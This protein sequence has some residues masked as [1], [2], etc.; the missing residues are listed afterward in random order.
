MRA[1]HSRIA[2]IV[3]FALV[4]ICCNSN[5]SRAA[6]PTV[7]AFVPTSGTIGTKITV[8][9]AGFTGTTAVK[10]GGAAAT[11]MV[12]SDKALVV[13]VPVNAATGAIFVTTAGGTGRSAK[14][15]TMIP[16]VKL[17]PASRRP[18]SLLNISGAGFHHST[19]VDVFFDTAD[20]ALSV[21]NGLGLVSA[22]IQVPSWAQPGQHWVT[23]VE[24]GTSAA[25]QQSLVVNTDWTMAGFAP[26]GRGFNPF[27]NTINASNVVQLAPTWQVQVSQFSNAAPFVALNGNL[28]VGE[29]GGNIKAVSSA[30]AVLWTAATG[31]SISKAPAAA[32]NRVFFPAADGNVRAYSA[33]CR[34]DGGVCAPLWTTSVGTNVPGDLVVFDG[35]VYA[36][37]SDGSIHPLDPVTGAAGTPIFGFDTAHGAVTT[38]VSFASEGFFYY[39]A[40]NTNLMYKTECCAGAIGE[41]GILSPIA[42]FSDNVY[43]T[44]ADGNLHA[45]GGLT[46]T[47]ATSG[48]FCIPAPVVAN[49]AVFAGGC[50]TLAAVDPGTGATRWSAATGSISGISVA[51]GV[52]YACDGGNAVAFSAVTGASL[53]TGGFCSIAPKAVNGTLYVAGN[54]DFTAY[55]LPGASGPSAVRPKPHVQDL[56]PDIALQPQRYQAL[57]EAIAE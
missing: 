39:G 31:S 46:W 25:A 53:W 49:G 14:A 50:N 17:S 6:A 19:A 35:Q 29:V 40:G 32:G 55:N 42:V 15:F 24:R 9:G 16:G 23:L 10:I 47:V 7:S 52:L 54:G 4:L 3:A 5:Q 48:T 20:L 26:S 43:F 13:T 1:R 11:F 2:L 30:G 51:N 37:S 33:T 44:T 56:H 8:K 27:E 18:L 28:F 45:F 41:G 36:P 22:Q 34:S 38:S 12:K 21:S 57:S